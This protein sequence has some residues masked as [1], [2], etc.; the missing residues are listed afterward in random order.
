[1]TY[2]IAMISLLPLVDKSLQV[3]LAFSSCSLLMFSV[4]KKKV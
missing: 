4:T 2:A 1:M 3:F